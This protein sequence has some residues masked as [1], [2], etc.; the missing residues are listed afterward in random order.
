LVLA[1]PNELVIMLASWAGKTVTSFGL[2]G[3]NE[4]AVGGY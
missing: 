3:I 1:N 4:Q 2:S